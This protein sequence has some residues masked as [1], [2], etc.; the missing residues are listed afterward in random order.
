MH[1]HQYYALYKPYGI[2]S[3]FSNKG[4]RE[5]LKNLYDFPKE[6]YPVGRLDADSEGLL[7]LTNDNQLK[8]RLLTPKFKHQKTYIVQV[9]GGVT[10]IALE[11]LRA[12]VEIKVKKQP[13]I[14]LPAVVALLSEDPSFLPARIPPIRFRANIPTSWL[15]IT[16]TEGKNRQIR[17]MTA[18][19]GFPTLR[20]V[21]THIGN[22]FVGERKPAEVWTYDQA[23]IYQMIG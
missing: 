5:G 12:G 2:L 18:K 16:I 11:R 23:A 17:K 13:Y 3:Q 15:Q 7:L 19:V 21:R 1:K 14:T 8:H 10:P 22:L 20:L 6:V 4:A 9:E